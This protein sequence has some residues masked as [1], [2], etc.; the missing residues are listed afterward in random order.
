MAAR[1]VIIRTWYLSRHRLR[2]QPLTHTVLVSAYSYKRCG[3]D[4]N[5]SFSCCLSCLPSYPCPSVPSAPFWSRSPEQS[6]G[7]QTL[8]G[9]A[10]SPHPRPPAGCSFTSA[11]VAAPPPGDPPRPSGCSV[12]CARG[13]FQNPEGGLLVSA[14]ASSTVTSRAW[15][16]RESRHVHVGSL[17]TCLGST[18]KKKK[19]YDTTLRGHSSG[20]SRGGVQGNVA[21]FQV[22]AFRA[23]D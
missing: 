8:S 6:C 21:R 19:R 16:R 17:A 18:E 7:A 4:G 22:E 9:L 3:V 11:V 2:Q 5:L 15:G 10:R 23:T 13:L 12:G 14:S 1:V 20:C